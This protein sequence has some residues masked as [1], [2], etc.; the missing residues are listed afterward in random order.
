MSVPAYG[1]ISVKEYYKTSK[2]KD[3]KVEIEKTQH[4]KITTVPVIVGAQVMI[5]KNW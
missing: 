1:Y 3:L 5:K 4:L 2:Y